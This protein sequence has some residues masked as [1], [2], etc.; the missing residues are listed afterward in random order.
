MEHTR[1][2]DSP[3]PPPGSDRRRP[4]ATALLMVGAIVAFFL[5]REHWNHLAGLWIYLLLLAC[6]LMHLFHS[7]GGHRSH[8]R[9]VDRGDRSRGR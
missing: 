8:D 7:H 9:Q 2:R 4:W 1:H 6:P 5:V 3:P